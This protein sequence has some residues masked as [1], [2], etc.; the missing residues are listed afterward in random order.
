MDS[1]SPGQKTPS[2]LHQISRGQRPQTYLSTGLEKVRKQK[3]QKK[4]L[5]AKSEILGHEYG[6]SD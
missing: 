4:S 2:N 1:T 6:K 5:D 3:D